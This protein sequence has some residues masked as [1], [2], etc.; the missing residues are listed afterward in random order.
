[1]RSWELKGLDE[2]MQASLKPTNL[3]LKLLFAV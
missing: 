2:N 3:L 1:M